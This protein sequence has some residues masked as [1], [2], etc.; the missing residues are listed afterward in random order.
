KQLKKER[1]KR[2]QKDELRLAAEQKEKDLAELKLKTEKAERERLE[3]IESDKQAAILKAEKE[4]REKLE[5]ELKAK[6]DAEVEAKK[7]EEAKIE[8]EL[9]KGDEAKID[10]LISELNSLKDKYTF[11]SAKNKK[12]YTQVGLLIDKVTNH[13]KPIK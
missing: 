4:A 7:Q 3:K 8:A 6:Q 11:K 5:A 13:I 2:D 10:D 9:N 1:L 12:I